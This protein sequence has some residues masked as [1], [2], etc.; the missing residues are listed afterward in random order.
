VGVDLQPDVA[1]R[2]A[3]DLLDPV[4]VEIEIVGP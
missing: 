4:E 1:E 2:V 3:A